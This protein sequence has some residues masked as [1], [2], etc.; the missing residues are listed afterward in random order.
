MT[1]PC[2]TGALAYAELGTMIPKSGGEYAYLL[3][4]LH[5]VFAFLFAWVSAW[6]LKPSGVAVIALTCAEYVLVP[7]FNDGCGS[8]PVLETKLLAI[9]VIRKSRLL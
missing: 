7:L 5:P 6:I 9:T 1:V 3:D 8:P 4:S 2:A